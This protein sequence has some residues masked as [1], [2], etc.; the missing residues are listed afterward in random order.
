SLS[1]KSKKHFAHTPRSSP[2][3]TPTTNSAPSSPSRKSANSRRNA[4]SIST[5]TPFSPPGKFP[6]T[7]NLSASISSQSPATSFT[8]PKE[9]ARFTSAAARAFNN[10]STAVT[11]SADSAP[12]QKMFPA[13]SASAKPQNLLASHSNPSHPAS[14]RC[15]T[16]WNPASLQ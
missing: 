8:H 2:S 9:S 1:I 7:S 16:N 4:T 5:L 13:L 15:E 11:I 3:C 10:F 12:A 6:S 14:V